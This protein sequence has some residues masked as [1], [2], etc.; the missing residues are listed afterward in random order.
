[1]TIKYFGASLCNEQRANAKNRI[2]SS[3]IAY[4]REPPVGVRRCMSLMIILCE[5]CTEFPGHEMP[6]TLGVTGFLPLHRNLFLELYSKDETEW[7]QYAANKV[8]TRKLRSAA[9]I[10]AILAFV[11][12]MGFRCGKSAAEAG[13]FFLLPAL[14]N[15]IAFRKEREIT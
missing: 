15:G 13:L 9:D 3:K 6:E 1:M 7:S 11:F 2:R 10:A 12:A 14:A 5:Q 8:V 4:F